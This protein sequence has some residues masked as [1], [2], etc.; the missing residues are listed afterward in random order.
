MSV[1]KILITIGVFVILLSAF[2]LIQQMVGVKNISSSVEENRDVLRLV[3][4]AKDAHYKIKYMDD[5]V[6]WNDGEVVLNGKI[7]SSFQYK[8]Y[9]PQ[10]LVDSVVDFNFNDMSHP[11]MSCLTRLS[12]LQ[13]HKD[14]SLYLSGFYNPDE[15]EEWIKKNYK[16]LNLEFSHS[17]FIEKNLTKEPCA[18]VGEVKCDGVYSLIKERYVEE[19]GRYLIY[20]E[21]YIEKDGKFFRATNGIKRSETL[22]RMSSKNF[23]LFSKEKRSE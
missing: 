6:E 18:I 3:D 12:S 9:T 19:L 4:V 14:F 20:P 5:S 17:L 21:V 13:Y 11:L 2:I 22:K 16:S 15:Q 8:V 23:S 7:V 10:L 1:K